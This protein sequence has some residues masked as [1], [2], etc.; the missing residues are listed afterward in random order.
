MGIRPGHDVLC[1]VSYPLYS[2][3]DCRARKLVNSTRARRT[4]PSILSPL[5]GHRLPCPET[6]KF[7]P[8]TTCCAQYPIHMTR[9]QTVVPGNCIDNPGTTCC[10]QYL[11]PMTRAQTAVPGNLYIRPGHDVQC[12]VP[13]PHDSGTAVC[14]RGMWI[15]YWALHV[16]PGSNLQV[17]G[18]G[19]LCPSQGG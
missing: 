7:D 1:P 11:I 19:S 17:S 16:V 9:A 13:Y 18:H 5:L 14:V 3:T 12:P 15:G 10:A 2:G 4:V 6:C 8:G